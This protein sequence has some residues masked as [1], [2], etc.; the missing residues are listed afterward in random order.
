[1]NGAKANPIVIRKYGGT[2][3][4]TPTLIARHAREAIAARER[5]LAPI[6]VVSAMSGETN[7]LLPLAQSLPEPPDPAESDAIA[8]TGE[9]VTAAL[10]AIAIQA[11]GGRARS[12][13]AHQLPIETDSHS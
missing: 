13:L 8:A 12:F 2:S 5:G 3:V 9:Q 1:M 7:R 4:A 6:L 10:T 11:A